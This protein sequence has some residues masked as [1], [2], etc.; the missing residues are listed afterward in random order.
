MSI[1]WCS[2]IE[3]PGVGATDNSPAVVAELGLATGDENLLGGATGV[4]AEPG[5]DSETDIPVCVE[6]A[7]PE[8]DEGQVAGAVS[9]AVDD[10]SV[11]VATETNVHGVV[12]ADREIPP[13][14][15]QILDES[16]EGAP[17]TNVVDEASVDGIPSAEPEEQS[18]AHYAEVETAADV[19][20]DQTGTRAI[21]QVSEPAIEVVTAPEPE[22]EPETERAYTRVFEQVAEPGPEGVTDLSTDTIGLRVATTEDKRAR[23]VAET[24][25]MEEPVVVDMVAT[26][27]ALAVDGTV[28]VSIKEPVV[29]VAQ[30]RAD[31][32]EPVGLI[33]EPESVVSVE[34]PEVTIGRGDVE[35]KVEVEAGELLASNV[36][37]H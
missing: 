11:D 34:T 20:A 2:L 14:Y 21:E 18:S 25:A 33:E 22:T 7:T 1:H 9:V 13:S 29:A 5:A 10:V 8:L 4:V 17:G 31:A 3:Q 27:S 15:P 12:G 35:P 16:E 23:E 28:G 19:G 36:L 37:M 30:I 24:E 6:A 26:A 32:P